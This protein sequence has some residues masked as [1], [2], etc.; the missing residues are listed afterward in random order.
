MSGTRQAAVV[1]RDY[2]PVPDDC[3]R[4]LSLLLR[5]SFNF[6]ASKGGPHDLT[7]NPTSETVKNGPRNTEREKP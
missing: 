6:Q 2:R 4:A 3:A 5:P 7:E 1:V